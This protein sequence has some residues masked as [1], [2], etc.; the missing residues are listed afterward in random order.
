MPV[1]W[2]SIHRKNINKLRASAE[3]EREREKGEKTSDKH[4]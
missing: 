1:Y 2:Y 3:K 4:Q